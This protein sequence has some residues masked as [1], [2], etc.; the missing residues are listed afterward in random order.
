LQPTVYQGQR[1]SVVL[2]NGQPTAHSFR[3]R[4]RSRRTFLRILREPLFGN[5]FTFSTSGDNHVLQAI[6]DLLDPFYQ[7]IDGFGG[8]PYL[9]KY[10]PKTND[11]RVAFAGTSLSSQFLHPPECRMVPSNNNHQSRHFRQEP[12]VQ[13]QNLP[14]LIKIAVALFGI[15][16]ALTRADG[17]IAIRKPGRN[18]YFF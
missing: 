9:F 15:S 12:L 7:C 5:S 18:I 16:I 1:T 14:Y 3:L 2:T 17:G 13:L 4:K 10:L 8:H 11:S 6:D